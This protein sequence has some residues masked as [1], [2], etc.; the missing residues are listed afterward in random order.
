MKINK[1]LVLG[2]V[3]ACLGLTACAPGMQINNTLQ[4]YARVENQISLGD[5]K[6]KVLALLEPL[7]RNLPYDERKP[8]ETY[9]KNGKTYFI[10]YM[11]S[12]LISDGVA[13]DDEFTPYQFEDGKLI[14]IGWTALGGPKTVAHPQPDRTPSHCVFDGFGGM[15]CF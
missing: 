15:T 9:I 5:S 8:S 13:T 3:V 1:L 7:Q 12:R 6:E 2:V 14:S 11:R 10:Y 4:N